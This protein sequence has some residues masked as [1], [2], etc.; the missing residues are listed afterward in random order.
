MSG[1]GG[2]Q[3]VQ[4]GTVNASGVF[5]PTSSGNPVPVS[6]TFSAT[7]APFAPNGNYTI[8]NAGT[9][10]ANVALP[11]GTVVEVFN[12][13][14]NLA[15]VNLGVGTLVAAST[16]EI[17]VSAGGW[18]GFAVGTNDH[19]AGITTTGTASLIL[20]G[21][22]GLPVG[23]AAGAGGGASGNVVVTS[24]TLT[25]ATV[26][27]ATGT[28]LHTVVDSGSIAIS[29]SPT[30]VVGSGTITTAT[31]TQATGTNLHTVVDSGTLTLGSV[32]GLAASG[33]SVSGNPL[34]GGGRAQN[35]E[36]TAVTNG[37]AIDIATDLVGRQ[38]VFPYANKENLWSGA[39]SSTGTTAVTIE[40][41]PGANVK[42]YA[43]SLQIGNTGTVT[44]AG[45]LNDSAATIL[46][47]P[48]GGGSN[49]TLPAPLVWA[50]NT[51]ATITFSAATTTAYASAQGFKGT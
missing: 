41:A 48:A 50:A 5:V 51:A 1:T 12:T 13:G 38:I 22:T 14:T 35:A 49:L 37:Q 9:A 36:Q 44:V 3:F 29:N 39:I 2:A 42:L 15:Y 8:L 46:V 31:V 11:T 7:L 40:A 23:S 33:A 26:T 28:N 45:T 16:V 27:Q 4:T 34:L 43:T 25:T 21:G 10:S 20:A 47:L 17:P 32:Q 19:L 18:L 30:V 24:G 6:G